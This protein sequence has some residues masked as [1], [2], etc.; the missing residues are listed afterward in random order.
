MEA[1]AILS[2]AAVLLIVCAIVF[3]PFMPGLKNATTGRRN[4]LSTSQQASVWLAEKE[5]L[6]TMIQELEFD[7][8]TGKIPDDLFI[9][10]RMELVRSAAEV[11]KK[12]DQIGYS[13]PKPDQTGGKSSSAPNIKEYD[14]LDE[15][16]A[17]RKLEKNGKATGFCPKCGSAL[18]SKDRFCPKCGM[19][20]QAAK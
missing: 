7:H 2:L 15:L 1:G 20:I 8:E 16:I 10:Q 3:R 14:D 5:R 13:E 17:R 19:T 11:L 12:L 9:E 6:L 4:R 18:Q